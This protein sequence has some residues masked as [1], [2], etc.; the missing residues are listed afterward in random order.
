MIE[1]ASHIKQN[2]IDHITYKDKAAPPSDWS[3]FVL[4]PIPLQQI[5]SVMHHKLSSFALEGAALVRSYLDLPELLQPP[6]S[7]PHIDPT[8][9]QRQDHFFT[10]KQWL[11]SVHKCR[12]K[13]Y[14][15]FPSDHFLLVVR[16]AARSPKPPQRPRLDISKVLPEQK[17]QFNQILQE[18]LEEPMATTLT[19]TP[20]TDT[21]P[22]HF[23][24]DCSGSTGKCTSS[25]PAGW[26]W[27]FR[28]GE[29]WTQ[30]CGPVVTQ[31]D[32]NA[33]RGAQVGSNNT[34]EVTAIIE[35]LLYAHQH[36][37]TEVHIHSDSRWAI[38]VIQGKWRPQHHK[39]LVNY[40]RN[41]L[42]INGG[43][44]SLHWIKARQ[45]MDHKLNVAGSF[46]GKNRRGATRP[47]R[48]TP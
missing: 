16:L 28:Q 3:Q 34:G 12:S 26:G 25:T 17:L 30:A 48:Q 39:S 9:F 5:Y 10:R 22:I 37:Y 24:N 38:N 1:A 47:Q 18:L 40:A 11:N 21:P 35:A 13:L 32:H 20:L 4:D 15:G 31:S 41:I 27:C 8:R 45:T 42:R 6:K 36:D 44:A 14:T 43:K 23:C 33:Y 46:G 2:P 7:I 29:N 19:T